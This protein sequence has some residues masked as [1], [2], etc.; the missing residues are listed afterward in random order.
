MK[1]ALVLILS[2]LVLLVV[3]GCNHDYSGMGQEFRAD[4][5]NMKFDE[6]KKRWGES[7]ARW[8]K[9]RGN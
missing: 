1:R 7:P 3:V 5:G 9:T 4:L 6:A 8:S 2:L